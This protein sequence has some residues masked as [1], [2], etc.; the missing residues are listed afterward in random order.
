MEQWGRIHLPRQGTEVRSLIRGGSTCCGAAKPLCLNHRARAPQPVSHSY[1]ACLL[2]P[3]K[4]VCSEPVLRNQRSP[5]R[6]KTVF[7]N[8]RSPHL[9]PLK[10]AHAPH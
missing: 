10:K 9:P 2:Q 8:Q 7:C 6:E 5:H 4:P 3:L 1:Q